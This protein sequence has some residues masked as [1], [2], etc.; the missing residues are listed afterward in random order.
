MLRIPD[1]AFVRHT[2]I[3]LNERYS[4]LN[5]ARSGLYFSKMIILS[6]TEKGVANG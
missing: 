2:H 5:Y 3:S 4:V 1:A 6:I